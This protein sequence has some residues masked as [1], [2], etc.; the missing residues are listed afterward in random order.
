MTLVAPA[1]CVAVLA[2]SRIAVPAANP[3]M[4]LTMPAGVTLRFNLVLG[5]PVW[6]G[7]ALAVRG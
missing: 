6:I 7:M 2:A 4:A 1:P 5:N 3:G